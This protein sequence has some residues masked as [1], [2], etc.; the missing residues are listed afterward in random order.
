MRG[1]VLYLL[2]LLSTVHGEVTLTCPVLF[3]VIDLLKYSAITEKTQVDYGTY[4]LRNG[5]QFPQPYYLPTSV[6]R[7]MWE[8]NPCSVLVSIVSDDAMVFNMEIQDWINAECK[9]LGK[10]KKECYKPIS[11]V[12]SQSD[13]V[14][15][16]ESTTQSPTF[17]PTVPAICDLRVDMQQCESTSDC[18]WFGAMIGCQVSEYC[19]FDIREACLMRRKYCKWSKHL[20]CSPIG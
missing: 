2:F 9:R 1:I 16:E 7:D 14:L 12:F 17:A 5:T 3:F 8:N 6:A 13:T 19:K 15:T 10:K 18:S 20:G 4:F 11:M